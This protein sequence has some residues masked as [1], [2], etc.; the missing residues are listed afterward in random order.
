MKRREVL[1]SLVGAASVRGVGTA[2]TSRS[3]TLSPLAVE[4]LMRAY[5]LEPQPGEAA[6]VSAFLLSVR[7]KTTPDP[8]IEPCIRLDPELD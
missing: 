7:P 3:Y 5:G 8:R 2:Q 6:Q 4:D 1:W